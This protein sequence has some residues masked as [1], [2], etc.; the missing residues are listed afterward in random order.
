MFHLLITSF[1][2]NN[3]TLLGPPLSKRFWTSILGSLI[4]KLLWF[5]VCSI[6]DDSEMY[7]Q[8]KPFRLDELVQI[9]AFLNTL[10][11]KMLWNDMV[12]GRYCLHNFKR[13]VLKF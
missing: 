5:S 8:Q 3:Q 4:Q 10:V 12:D 1:Y 2:L 9:S 7:E 6:I 11:F 13:T